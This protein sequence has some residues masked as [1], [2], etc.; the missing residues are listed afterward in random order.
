MIR[1]LDAETLRRY[2][3]LRASMFRDRADQFKRRLNWDVTVDAQGFETDEYDAMNPVY[4]IWQGA[5]GRHGG[6]M[7]VM[8]TE[9]PTMIEDH[10]AHLTGGRRIAGPRIWECTRFCLS[11][12][13][14]PRVAGALMLAGAQFGM[15]VGLTHSVGVF[16]ARMVLIYRRIGWQP[17]VLGTQGDGRSAISVGLWSIDA[18]LPARLTRRAGLSAEIVDHAFAR[19]RGLSQAA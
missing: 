6:S 15:S 16:D 10:F 18:D 9:G 12:S 1:F 4:V 3:A 17:T 14:G 19:D 8:P 13:A 5:D 7:R 2:P 11:P